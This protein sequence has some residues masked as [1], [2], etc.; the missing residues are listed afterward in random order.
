M[1]MATV[2]TFPISLETTAGTTNKKFPNI[3]TIT[4][5]DEVRKILSLNGSLESDGS[6]ANLSWT[7]TGTISFFKLQYGTDRN[8][9]KL[10]LTTTKAEGQFP[11]VEAGKTYYA[12]VFPIDQAAVVNGE[13][14]QII[15]IKA[16][17]TCGNSLI[18]TGEEC[19]DGNIV[20]GDSCSVE[21]KTSFTA[22][23]E[24]VATPTCNP[25][26][27]IKLKTKK[28]GSQYYLYR[29]SVPGAQKYMVYRKDSAPSTLNAVGELSLV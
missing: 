11:L 24:P 17:S 3:D 29:G 8:D 6:K 26:S 28:I 14:S 2:G 5:G 10:S 20:D 4:V 16:K 21:C 18:E 22:P 7:Y 9:M 27:G 25:P 15:E 19:D 1:Q 23:T 13:P 12:Q